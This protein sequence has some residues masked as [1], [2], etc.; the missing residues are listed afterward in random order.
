MEPPQK[1]AL[2]K[3]ERVVAPATEPPSVSAP[4]DP[5]LSG[6]R[7]LVEEDTR[8]S[9]LKWAQAWRA[10]FS[11]WWLLLPPITRTRLGSCMGALAL[12]I[13]SKVDGLGIGS[14]EGA[15]ASPLG[16]SSLGDPG[17]DWVK[18]AARELALPQLAPALPL[19]PIPSLLPRWWQL[20]ALQGRLSH[21]GLSEMWSEE[22]AMGG[23]ERVAAD[24]MPSSIDSLPLS[25]H[26]LP[27]HA[28]GCAAGLVVG[29]SFSLFFSRRESRRR[30]SQRGTRGQ[31]KARAISA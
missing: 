29:V 27:P 2:S 5:P 12:H 9:P 25:P 22:D 17:C 3:C 11:C 8:K 20:Q 4:R 21:K 16:E 31:Y 19:P 6:N 23:S 30:R 18:E 28:M 7:A 24:A 13:G 1:E 15:A 14:S 10:R 26:A